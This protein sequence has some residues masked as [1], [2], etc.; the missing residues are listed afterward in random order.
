M[1]M[2]AFNR[3]LLDHMTPEERNEYRAGVTSLMQ[4]SSVKAALKDRL[5][6]IERELTALDGAAKIFARFIAGGEDGVAKET[7]TRLFDS[8]LTPRR[9]D[10]VGAVKHMRN[11]LSGKTVDLQADLDYA[12]AF[13]LTRI[14]DSYGIPY[15][16]VG[17]RATLKCPFHGEGTPSFTV[18]LGQNNAHCYGCNWHGDTIDFVKAYEHQDFR[19]AVKSIK[20][21]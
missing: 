6:A 17:Q 1:S 18:Y 5:A 19:G 15:K 8:D 21:K 14:L 13:P 11:M 9:A 3:H 4:L 10:L 12:R 20:G 7:A 16:E 2:D